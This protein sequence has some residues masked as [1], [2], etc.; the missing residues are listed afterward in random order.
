MKL[1]YLAAC[2][3]S[4]SFAVST[5]VTADALTTVDLFSNQTKGMQRMFCL[6]DETGREKLRDAKMKCMERPKTNLSFATML[7]IWGAITDAYSC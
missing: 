3:A 1:K 7:T 4:L 2:V 6:S 5:T